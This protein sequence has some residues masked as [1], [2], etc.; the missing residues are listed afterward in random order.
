MDETNANVGAE[1]VNVT[2]NKETQGKPEIDYEAEYKKMK[3]ECAKLKSATDKA[4]SQAAD[5]KRQLREKQSEAERLEAD[6]QEAEAAMKA[7]LEAF[8]QRE[9]ISTYKSK[10]MESGYDSDSAQ[11]MAEGLPD[12]ISDEFF[13][14]QKTFLEARA[15]AIES[16]LLGKQPGLSSGKT[17]S[18]ADIAD[19]EYQ[20]MRKYAGLN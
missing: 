8:R 12:G 18:S 11:K 13:T 2:E 10:L 16:E 4:C 1:D 6:R 7:E 15:K 20:K 14:A 9:K 19:L 5:M 17:P 3:A